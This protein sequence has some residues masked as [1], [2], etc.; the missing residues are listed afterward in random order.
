MTYNYVELLG[1]RSM[2]LTIECKL[3]L[4]YEKSI[5]RVFKLMLYAKVTNDTS[6]VY[7]SK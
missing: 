4:Y 6:V 7:S 5:Y 1:M 3:S 2:H